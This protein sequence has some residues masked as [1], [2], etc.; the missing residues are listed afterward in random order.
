VAACDRLGLA[1]KDDLNRLDHEGIAYLSYTLRDGVRQSAARAF[2][3]PVRSR[4]NLRVITGAKVT[5]VLFDGTRASAVE[6]RVGGHV[7]RFEASRDIILSAG[8][9]ES[10]RL[11]QLSGVGDGE[12]LQSLGIPTVAHNP[13]VGLNLREHLLYMAQWRLKAWRHSQNREFSGWRLAVNAAKYLIAKRGVLGVGAYPVGGF[14]KTVA[15]AHRPDAQV[16]M[17]PF[18]LD[19]AS[20]GMSMEKAPGMQLFSYGL[21]PNSRGQVRI[22]SV[23]PD[24]PAHVDPNYLADEEDRRIAVASMHF[25][26]RVVE[27]PEMATLIAEET[28]PGPAVHSDEQMLES[29]RSAGQSGYHAC[30]T[31]RIGSD[32]QSVVDPRLKVRGVQ[33]LRV[34]DLSIAPTMLSGNTNGPVMAMAWRGAEL[35]LADAG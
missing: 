17:C 9:L 8:T 35:I 14:Y 34:L 22:A 27:Q 28:R 3:A 25:M 32:D 1:R 7:R 2:L 21:R 23:D 20:G 31:C 33:G 29:F 18:T 30:G 19:F 12:H 26:R 5:R 6:A 10:P 24:V 11:L 4:P 13:G 15:T 16:M